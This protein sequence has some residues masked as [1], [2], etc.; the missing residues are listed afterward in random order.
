MGCATGGDDA[1]SAPDRP[2]GI[3]RVLRKRR[4]AGGERVT[5]GTGVGAV[6][7]AL[8]TGRMECTDMRDRRFT[9]MEFMFG[10]GSVVD[11]RSSAF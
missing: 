10:G 4:G 3:E 6:G 8:N 2:L 11:E 7:G 9:R 5:S 1:P